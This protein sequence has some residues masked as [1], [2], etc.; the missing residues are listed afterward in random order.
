[1]DKTKLTLSAHLALSVS[2]GVYLLDKGSY[3]Q[4]ELAPDVSSSVVVTGA[5]SEPLA[6]AVVDS[7]AVGSLSCKSGVISNL[8]PET[9]YCTDGKTAGFVL[10]SKVAGDL[11]DE[12][13][14]GD[15]FRLDVSA[16]KV[17]VDV[18]SSK[19]GK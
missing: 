15:E 12:T 8:P 3:S 17:Y 4:V 6:Q 5:A 10:P 16:G 18:V 9:V 13:D 11:L 1:M 19:G 7:G 2:G 14:H